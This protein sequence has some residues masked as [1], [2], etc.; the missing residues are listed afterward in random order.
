M[1]T[2]GLEVSRLDGQVLILVHEAIYD[3]AVERLAERATA[4]RVGAPLDTATGMEPLVSEIEMQR[5]LDDIDVGVREGASANP[6]EVTA[7]RSIRP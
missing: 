6:L 3:E 5:V 1:S 7:N 4:I 2:W